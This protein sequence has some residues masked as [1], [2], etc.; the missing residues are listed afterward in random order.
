MTVRDLDSQPANRVRVV[1]PRGRR[2]LRVSTREPAVFL[3]I[4]G[5]FALFLGYAAL[6]PW[7]PK[8]AFPPYRLATTLVSLCLAYFVLRNLVN[9]TTVWVEGG[10]L[11]VVHGPLPPLRRTELPLRNLERIG[12]GVLQGTYA[13]YAGGERKRIAGY[14]DGGSELARAIVEKLEVKAELEGVS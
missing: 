11:V 4:A 8:L 3:L 1:E 14:E 10:R 9:A 2:E 5:G 7:T 13:L 6:D 12:Y